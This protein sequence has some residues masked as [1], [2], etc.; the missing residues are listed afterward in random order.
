[1]KKWTGN[2]EQMVQKKQY[3]ANL[4]QLWKKH[5]IGLNNMSHLGQIRFNE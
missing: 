2:I 3:Y 5:G 1:M 4:D